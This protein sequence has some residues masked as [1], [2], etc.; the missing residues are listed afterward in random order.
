MFFEEIFNSPPPQQ[1]SLKK[2]Y[3]KHQFSQF[4]TKNVSQPT[5]PTPS[6]QTN[7]K[8][9]KNL[10]FL[11]FKKFIKTSVTKNKSITFPLTGGGLC[12]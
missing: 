2:N 10:C 8:S 7:E 11:F 3:P 9:S 6:P 1:K 4:L 12:S 5:T